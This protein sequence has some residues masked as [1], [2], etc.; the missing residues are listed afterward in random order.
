MKKKK[1]LDWSVKMEVWPIGLKGSFDCV[2]S[3][4]V[5][6]ESP[7]QD[8]RICKS[9]VQEI[10]FVYG[11][12]K[13]RTVRSAIFFAITNGEGRKAE[14][15]YVL[16]RFPE[17]DNKLTCYYDDDTFLKPI[18]YKKAKDSFRPVKR[19]PA[20]VF[21]TSDLGKRIFNRLKRFEAH[22]RTEFKEKGITV[23]KDKG[24]DKFRFAD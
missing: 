24:G 18:P 17:E 7:K 15:K 2:L 20:K 13:L 3:Q 12:K 14:L 19:I 22:I 11:L 8:H 21:K 4:R 6:T 16:G 5:G 10:L 1:D 23:K 9:I